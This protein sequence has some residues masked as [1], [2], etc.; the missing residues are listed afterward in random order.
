MNRVAELLWIAP[1]TATRL[2]HSRKF[3]ALPALTHEGSRT[4]MHCFQAEMQWSQL[5]SSFLLVIVGVNGTNVINLKVL[6][7]P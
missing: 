1:R 4:D 5:N 3:A 6:Q 7:R 2:Y